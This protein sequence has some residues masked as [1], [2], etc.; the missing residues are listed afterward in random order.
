MTLV[1]DRI[2]ADWAGPWPLQGQMATVYSAT[3]ERILGWLFLDATGDLFPASSC[4]LAFRRYWTRRVDRPGLLGLLSA[5]IDGDELEQWETEAGERDEAST[6]WENG[7]VVAADPDKVLML[8]LD[9]AEWLMLAIRAL[10]YNAPNCDRPPYDEP[11][12]IAE[13]GLPLHQGRELWVRMVSSPDGQLVDGCQQYVDTTPI[14]GPGDPYGIGITVHFHDRTIPPPW[15]FNL[16]DAAHFTV[17]VEQLIGAAPSY[18]YLL[19][20]DPAAAELDG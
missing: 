12:I 15:T 3:S 18:T 9:Q 19:A 4:F 6:D 14:G 16:L 17:M 10:A 11:W 7:E 13:A 20:E 1:G 5:L 8:D 2:H